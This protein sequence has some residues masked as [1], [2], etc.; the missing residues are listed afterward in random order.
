MCIRDR[1]Q[2]QQQQQQQQQIRRNEGNQNQQQ[3][4]QAESNE[5]KTWSD[6]VGGYLSTGGEYFKI[7]LVFGATKLAEGIK[8]GGSYI[9]EKIS[10]AEE[11]KVSEGTKATLKLAKTATGAALIFTQAQVRGL[12]EV[13][14][15]VANTAADSFE[16]SDTGKKLETNEGYQH[17]KNIGKA[18]LNVFANAF[19]GFTEALFT[20][21]RGISHATTGIV[22]KLSLIHI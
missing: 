7:G 17:A 15:M 10:P 9:K 8:S 1:R 2:P 13:S 11:V 16:R 19:D 18:S 12:I 14:K 5:N 20:L 4:E 21:G 3:Q 22:H 6:K